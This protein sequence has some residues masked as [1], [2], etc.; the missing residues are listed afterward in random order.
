[1]YGP[2][3]ARLHEEL[4]PITAR[5]T[6]P[7]IRKSS[8]SPYGRESETKTLSLLDKA[9]LSGT[10]QTI[11]DQILKQLQASAPRD[12]EELLPQLQ[13]RGEEYAVDA[14][15]KLKE[16]GEAEAKAMREILETQKKYI[17]QTIAK[18][19]RPDQRTLFEFLDD[20]RRQLESNRRYWDK[21]LTA[22]ETELRTEPDRIRELYDVKATRIEP[23]GLVY[24]WPVTG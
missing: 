15:K 11:H 14:R 2:G 21:R 3:A 6:D 7:K 18:H 8:L 24:L 17:A 1:L 4:I 20:E 23:I 22:L 10:G 16:R 9:L 12:I 19:D 13:R 5:W